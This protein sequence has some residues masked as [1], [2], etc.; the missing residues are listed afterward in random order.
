MEIS[1]NAFEDKLLAVLPLVFFG[2]LVFFYWRA[3]KNKKRYTDASPGIFD[4]WHYEVREDG[5]HGRSLRCALVNYWPA[6]QRL[7]DHKDYY[8]VMLSKCNGHIIPK[9]C[10]PNLEAAALFVNQVNLYLEGHLSA[11]PIPIA[12]GGEILSVNAAR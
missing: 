9:R 2:I 12:V 11:A 3:S 10:F 5:L 7:V 8:F 1:H 6:V 4:D